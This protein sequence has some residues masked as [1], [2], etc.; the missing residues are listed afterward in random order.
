MEISI[1][2]KHKLI[3]IFKAL[4]Q[5]PEAMMASALDTDLLCWSHGLLRKQ[6]LNNGIV[7]Q[8]HCGHTEQ[9]IMEEAKKKQARTERW[10]DCKII[11]GKLE[12]LSQCDFVKHSRVHLPLN[13]VSDQKHYKQQG[14]WWYLPLSRINSVWDLAAEHKKPFLSPPPISLLSESI[15]WTV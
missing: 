12:P 2:C 8:W 6:P 9:H 11:S 15:P 5:E 14:I 1:T 3:K 7:L 13:S 4:Q 10:M